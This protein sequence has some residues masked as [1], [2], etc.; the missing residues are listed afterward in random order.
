MA[1]FDSNNDSKSEEEA[2]NGTGA[3]E[4]VH[5]LDPNNKA[6]R[7]DKDDYKAGYNSEK[8][9]YDAEKKSREEYQQQNPN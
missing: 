4:E 9:A 3:H 1:D 5:L 7:K 8:P 6:A 2:I